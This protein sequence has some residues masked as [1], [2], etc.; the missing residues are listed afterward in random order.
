MVNTME[1]E[2]Q[3]LFLQSVV[4]RLGNEASLQHLTENHISTTAA[5]LVMSYGIEERRILAHSDKGCSLVDGE[6]RRV[7]SEICLRGSLYSDCVVK[8]I[9]LIEIQR[10]DFLLCIVFFELNGNNPLYRLLK[11]ALKAVLSNISIKLLCK[12]LSDG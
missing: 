8:E 10:D 12:L 1:V 7:F 4:L 5:T 6:L 2:H 3:R 11:S 9:E